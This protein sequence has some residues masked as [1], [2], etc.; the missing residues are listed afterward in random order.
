MSTHTYTYPDVHARMDCRLIQMYTY[1][2][3]YIFMHT[4][5]QIATVGPMER[6][7][8]TVAKLHIRMTISIPNIICFYVDSEFVYIYI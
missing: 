3:I 8:E 5:N 7:I 2:R 4:S 6:P 1:I